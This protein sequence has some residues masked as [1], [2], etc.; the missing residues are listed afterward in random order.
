MKTRI[1]QILFTALVAFFLIGGNVNAKGTELEIA[2]SYENTEETSLILED[3]MTEDNF[4][5]VSESEFTD[6]ESELILEEWMIENSL[7]SDKYL[8]VEEET[9]S[10]L[11]LE[12]WM[13]K[14][15]C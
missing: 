11:E 13:I 3:W 8:Q 1:S 7:W 2:S 14:T 9:D 4:W 12:N 15:D 6:N 10:K 5:I